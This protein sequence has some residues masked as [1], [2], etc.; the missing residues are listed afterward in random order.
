MELMDAKENFLQYLTI[1]KGLAIKTIESYEADLNIFFLSLHGVKLAQHLTNE[2]I[3]NFIMKMSENNNSRATINR[4]ISTIKSFYHFLQNESIIIDESAKVEVPS[5]DKYLPSVLTFE[6]VEALLEAPKI[7][8]LEELRDRSMLEL[9]Y[10][11]GLRVSEL[12]N[13]E[14]KS[15]NFEDCILRVKGKGSKDR[16]LPFSEYARDYMVL[17]FNQFRNKIE[18]KNCKYFFISKKGEQLS[19]QFFWKQ[20]KKYALKAGIEINVSP[21]TLRHSFATHLLE[22]GADLRLVQELL[23]HSSINTTEI[24]THVSFKRIQSTYDM[25]MNKKKK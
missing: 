8:K 1:E 14:T 16:I 13:V 4:R 21:H 6:E 24:Y 15:I 5:L 18:Y 3:E 12:L 7:T 19:R 17:Y 23:G 25:Y 2:D 9:M 10:S 11:S 22:G 20:V